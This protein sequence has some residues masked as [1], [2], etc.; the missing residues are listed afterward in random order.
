MT[1]YVNYY[2]P[3]GCITDLSTI[4]LSELVATAS[5]ETMCRSCWEAENGYPDAND[6]DD[7]DDDD[8]TDAEIR[9]GLSYEDSD[10][11]DTPNHEA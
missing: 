11:D 10:D 3:G 9:A 7:I 6:A 2:C 5:G 1:R 4:P 8:Y